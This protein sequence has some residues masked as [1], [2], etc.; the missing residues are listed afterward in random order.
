MNENATVVPAVNELRCDVLLLYATSSEEQ[1]LKETSI[2]IGIQIVK[3]KAKGPSGEKVEFF[4]LGTVGSS[5]VNAIR[6][7]MGPLSYGGSASRAIYYRTITGA[8]ALIQLGMAFGVAPCEQKLGDV[9]V[10]TSLIPYDLRIVR[11]SAAEL[12]AFPREMIE[13]M[14]ASD[15]AVTED[16]RA[17]PQPGPAQGAKHCKEETVS[18]ASPQVDDYVVD[19]SPAERHRARQALIDMFEAERESMS[20]AERGYQVFFGGVLSGG[21]RVFSRKFVGELVMGVPQAEDGVVGGEM[22]GVGL[23]SVSPANDPL[24]CVVKG[25][26]DFG[27]EDRDQ[28]IKESRPVACKNSAHFVLS[29][30]MKWG[31][32]AHN[33]GGA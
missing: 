24:W 22:E 8:T 17:K 31:P 28:V 30:L 12:V 20:D 1:M 26:S 11:T 6:T 14:V 32:Q 29:A 16:G 4:T 23:L 3:R 19:Y 9:L 15:E 21:A 18:G 2:A 10:S 13:A 33:V 7:K 25:I 27:D 5:R